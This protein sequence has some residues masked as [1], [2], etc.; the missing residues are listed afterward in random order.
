[1]TDEEI[2]KDDIAVLIEERDQTQSEIDRRIYDAR[3]KGIEV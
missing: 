3:Q 2:I 1:M